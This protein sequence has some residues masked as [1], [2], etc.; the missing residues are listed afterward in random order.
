[1]SSLSSLEAVFDNGR[2]GLRS[3]SGNIT[4]FSFTGDV[5][6]IGDVEKRLREN[7]QDAVMGMREA[8][9]ADYVVGN[10][11]T[12]LSNAP[13][14]PHRGA[15]T[16][17]PA[18]AGVLVSLGFDAFTMANNHTMD[19]GEEGLRDTLAFLSQNNISCFGAGV[20]LQ[21]AGKP[22]IVERNN[23]KIGLLGYSQ[24]E[25]DAAGPAHAGVAPLR[26]ELI[27]EGVAGL[28]PQ[29]DVI[30][31]ALHEGYEFQHYPRLEFLHLCRELAENGVDLICGHHPHVL[32]G[33]ETVG[34]SL[35]LYS[36]GNFWFDMAYHRS[37][38]ETREGLIAHVSF[39]KK[40]PVF[41]RLTPTVMDEKSLLRVS[42]ED[43]RAQILKH[44]RNI[45]F[46]LKDTNAVREQNAFSTAQV[47]HAVLGAVYNLG[48]NDDKA[49][50]EKYVRHQIRRDPYLKTFCDYA[51]LIGGYKRG[52]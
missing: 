17:D 13:L 27:L 1:M 44:L 8:L 36:L 15:L 16:S 18:L 30:I 51:E 19:C 26:K 5:C 28:R 49:G 21:D 10:L 50:F 42:C 32:Q 23:I 35:I 20:N 2:Q 48:H 12:P 34:N 14:D 7:S 52:F 46:L 4:T 6:L 43:H 24:P 39:D 22:L 3:S 45:S 47:M 37:V 41:L 25:L 29:V 33:M 38:P 11:E 31:L 9:A 40:G